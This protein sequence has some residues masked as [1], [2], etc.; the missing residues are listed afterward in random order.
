V[1]AEAQL[2]DQSF[3]TIASA[4]EKGYLKDDAATGTAIPAGTGTGWFDYDS[5]THIISAISERTI[6]I[7]TPANTYA[8]VEILSYYEGQMP[9]FGTPRFYTFQ[10][11]HQADGSRK[12]R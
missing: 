5:S 12:F 11:V 9:E 8:K 2:I 4:P 7:R 3:E 6:V 10:F 1:N